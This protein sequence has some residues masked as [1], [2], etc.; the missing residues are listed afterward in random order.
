LRIVKRRRREARQRAVDWSKAPKVV[1]LAGGTI[2]IGW[3]AV[4]TAAVDALVKR[5]PI[6]AASFAPNDP[7][8]APILA[9]AEF[10]QK[11]GLVS[12]P[13]AKA[14]IQSLQKN[15]LA[16]E[17]FLVAS[18]EA[19]KRGDEREAQLLLT[20]VRKRNPRSRIGRILL[21]DRHLRAKRVQ[22]A[23]I[24]ITGIGRLMPASKDVLVPELA[25]FAADPKTRPA[26]AAVLDTNQDMKRKL[27]EHLAGNGTDPDLVL[28]LA[29]NL[30]VGTR[31]G[32]APHWQNLL[33]TRLVD[34]G[35]LT[36]ARQLWR[37]F[38]G[39]SPPKVDQPV[40]DPG[41]Q[42]LPGPAPFN[43][44]FTSSPAGVAEP[45]KDQALQVEYYGRV[46]ADFASQLLTLQPGQYQIAFRA[47]GDSP[48]KGS[49]LSWRLVC[50][51]S[52]VEVAAVPIG[53]LSYAPKAISSRFAVPRVGC[54]GQWLRLVGTPAE[55][56][57]AQSV[58][59][60]DL[61]IRKAGAL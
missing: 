32:D 59:I 6:A 15:P 19:L 58:T 12:P 39:A 43:W 29:G 53:E 48:E 5:N 18:I 31:P 55:F 45:T 11:Q 40:Y 10:R 38:A 36:E 22:Q 25:R 2:F 30:G 52:K 16:E 33:L 24:E 49:R 7:R 21:L 42:R 54:A 1:L 44:Q 61:E 37:R 56:P 3:L 9:M 51:P 13:V 28:E 35:D 50:Q 47:T 8:I 23:A 27:L 17:P 34:K 20:E 4:K 41:F 60:R 26:L 57:T 14:A 46:D